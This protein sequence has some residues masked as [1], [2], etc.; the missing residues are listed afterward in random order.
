MLVV[1]LAGPLHLCRR[2]S[3]RS[4]AL[5]VLWCLER[6]NVLASSVAPVPG[7]TSADLATA[8]Q[9]TTLE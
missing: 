7:A 6:V 1:L 8:E 2:A 3:H 5:R 9:V 4:E